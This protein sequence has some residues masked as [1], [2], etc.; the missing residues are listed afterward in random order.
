MKEG[1]QEKLYE[2][3]VDIRGIDRELW[4][5]VRA[6]AVRRGQSAGELV[7]EIFHAWLADQAARGKEL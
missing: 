4:L 3:G 2:R 5:R 7:T 6:E 1:T